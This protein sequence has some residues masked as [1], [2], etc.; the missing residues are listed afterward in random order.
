MKVKNFLYP[1]YFFD[2]LFIITWVLFSSTLILSAGI[3]YVNN[4]VLEIIFKLTRYVSYIICLLIIIRHQIKNR[5]IP[6][7][8]IFICAF[9][10]SGV[11]SGNL[12]Y[13]LYGI[14]LL[15]SLDVNVNK[16]IKMTALLQFFYLFLIVLLSQLN[17]ILDFVFDPMGR[18]RHGL[19]FNWTTTGPILF[20]YLCLCLINITKKK[21]P[22]VMI[23]LLEIINIWFFYL[24]DSKMAC[25]LLT[26]TLLFFYLYGKSKIIRK[27]LIKFQNIYIIFPF[28]M[29][30]FTLLIV[31]I[32]NW[33]IPTW[34]SIDKALSY[35]LGLAQNAYN[36]Y[37]IRLL[38]QSIHWVGFDYKHLLAGENEIYN[39]VDNSYLQIAF[40]NGLIFIII[41]LCIYS[42]GIYK[43]IKNNDYVLVYTYIIV[44]IFSLTEPRLM[45]FAFN[46]LPLI[47]LGKYPQKSDHSLTSYRKIKIRI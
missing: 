35:R 1:Y 8:L 26:L 12:T 21:I 30:G 44:L 3:F 47:A 9:L 15:A 16:I 43:A 33:Y 28:L 46:P 17:I 41:V 32:Y 34:A 4:T 19:G 18:A 7:I 6:Y 2:T 13:P 22:F 45:N 20:F 39:Y 29:F 38:G 36:K 42:Y 37:G 24:T 14:L 31:K 11:G 10:L 27:W 40:N 25:I 23:I 5:Q